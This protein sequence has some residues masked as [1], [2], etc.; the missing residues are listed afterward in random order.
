MATR[1][2]G[3][4]ISSANDIFVTGNSVAS[5]AEVAVIKKDAQKVLPQSVCVILN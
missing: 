1:E 5:T 4:R 2:H 3:N